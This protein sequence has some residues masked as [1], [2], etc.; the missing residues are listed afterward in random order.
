MSKYPSLTAGILARK[1]EAEPTSTPFADQML[2]RVGC[3]APEIAGLTPMHGH[4]HVHAEPGLAKHQGL[5]PPA[6]K[7]LDPFGSFGRRVMA[8]TNVSVLP[9]PALVRDVHPDEEEHAESHCGTCPGPSP[10]EAGKT[11]HVNLRLKRMRF[12]K[13]KLSA[14]LLRRP[15]QEIVAEALDN[16]FDTLP[17]D[18]LGDCACLR[19]RGD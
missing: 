4:T 6:P 5:V 10:E 11:Y 7:S 8:D 16:W 15:V 14:A 1:G 13:L 2:T 12:V 9:M 3:P 18:V 19:A 17:G